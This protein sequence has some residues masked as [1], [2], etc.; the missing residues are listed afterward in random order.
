MCSRFYI[1]ICY[2]LYQ[3]IKKHTKTNSAN[4]NTYFKRNSWKY[5]YQANSN[6]TQPTFQTHPWVITD[7]RDNC[8]NIYVSNQPSVVVEIR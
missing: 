8:L 1:F 4:Q 3:N 6:Y 2:Y 5:Q 7:P